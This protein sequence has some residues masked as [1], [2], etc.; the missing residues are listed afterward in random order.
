MI[1]EKAVEAAARKMVQMRGF[2]PEE[3]IQRYGERH[4]A[5]RAYLPDAR[6]VLIAAIPHLDEPGD[7]ATIK[8]LLD[9][10]DA[11]NMPNERRAEILALRIRRATPEEAAAIPALEEQRHGG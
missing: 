5:W 1:S 8:R 11:E 10:M 9:D 4:I 7:P 3:I 2:D 6:A